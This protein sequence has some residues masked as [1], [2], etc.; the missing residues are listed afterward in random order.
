[1]GH[2]INSQLRQLD[3]ALSR[4]LN[5]ALQELGSALATI[6]RHLTDAYQRTDQ[7]N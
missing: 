4:Q 7:H 1:M 5:A 2:Y 3:E 6:A